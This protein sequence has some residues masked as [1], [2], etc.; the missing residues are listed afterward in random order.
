MALDTGSWFWHGKPV[1][2]FSFQVYLDYNDFNQTISHRYP[3][4]LSVI[5]QNTFE[6]PL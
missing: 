4:Y 5:P 6:T 1:S 2:L 3:L